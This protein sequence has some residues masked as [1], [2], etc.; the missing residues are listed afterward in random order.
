MVADRDWKSFFAH[1]DAIT[2]SSDKFLP[3]PV[4]EGPEFSLLII[5]LGSGL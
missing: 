5:S 1:L 2:P 4:P 3:Y